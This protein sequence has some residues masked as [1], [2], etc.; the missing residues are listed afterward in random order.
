MGGRIGLATVG[1]VENEMRGIVDILQNIEA[2]IP[3]LLNRRL[4]VELTGLPKG[5]DCTCLHR[6]VHQRDRLFR[7]RL[8]ASSGFSTSAAE[9]A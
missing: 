3:E 2:P 7:Q 4:V 5:R 1:C 6:P 8:V 9:S